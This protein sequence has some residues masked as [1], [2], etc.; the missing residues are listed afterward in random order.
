MADS[1]TLGELKTE[2]WEGRGVYRT[3]LP[4]ARATALINEGIASL[5]DEMQLKN[6]KALIKIGDI[7]VS[8]G[9]NTYDLS[10]EFSDFGG[11]V[12]LVAFVKD[13]NDW[14]PLE[15]VP[16]EEGLVAGVN[17]YS[18]GET[19]QVSIVGDILY[20]WPTPGWTG[21][22]KVFYHDTFTRLSS[23]NDTYDFV[24][25]WDRYVIDFVLEIVRDKTFE[26]ATA[27]QRR[28]AIALNSI[29]A[30]VARRQQSGAGRIT[31]RHRLRHKARS[32]ITRG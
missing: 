10:T 6:P 21:T 17:G 29:L 16:L 9:D 3:H 26:D 8:S 28:M 5:R 2:I 22:L 18:E 12:D 30:R 25:G 15:F 24:Q 11:A 20:L 14:R 1:R 32:P 7:T 27:A 13:T 19:T 31:R 4:D 23:D